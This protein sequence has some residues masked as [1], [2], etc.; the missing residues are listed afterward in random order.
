MERVFNINPFKNLSHEKKVFYAFLLVHLLVWT[1]IAMIRTVM[2]TDTLEGI[3]WGQHLDFGTPKHP[4]LA[5]WLTYFAWAPFKSD[6]VI[7]LMSQMFIIGGFVYIYRLAKFFLDENQAILS[8]I[9]LEGCWCYSYVTGYY[10]FNPDVVLLLM[11]PALAFYFYKC[12]ADDK[13][14]DWMKLGI[15]V[16]LSCLNKYQT[17]LMILPMAIW[18]LFFNRQTFKNKNFYIAVAIAF[19]I[20]L[21]HLLWLIKYD[22]YPLMYFEEELSSP[23][24]YTH[25]TAPL[26]FL[27]VQIGA[28]A[29]SLLIFMACKYKAKSSY[30][31]V[32]YTDRRHLWF[33]ILFGFIPL[34]VHLTLGVS[35]G[36]TMRPRWGFEFLFMTG[37]VLF[38]FLPCK[39]D[40]KTFDFTVKTAYAVMLIIMLIFG[41]L[42]SVE[43]NFRSRYEV[44]PV[45]S[46]FNEIWANK[47]DTPL[48][49][50]GGYIEYTLPLT[51]YGKTHP[52]N[53]LD[54]HGYPS[55]WL[56]M[57]DLKKS[58]AII[59]DRYPEGVIHYTRTTV[60]YLPKDYK[61]VPIPYRFTIT[62]SYNLP[63]EYT[64]YYFII[65][66]M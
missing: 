10:G 12:M 8:V 49:Y 42:L 17:G 39:I 26:L 56:N 30:T 11:L 16:G 23:V 25:I 33:L 44:A 9:L 35:S 55:P 2:Q 15:W 45:M 46:D 54:T 34:I 1:C 51:I 4:P 32:E 27:V 13:P 57:H 22:F 20:F 37:I 60:P 59:I 53:I 6:F 52:A 66:P 28:I 48:K 58:G 21:P 5:A 31:I 38:Y 29:G 36:G 24:W 47:Y 18:A 50:V 65:P 43:K 7:Y 64:I 62:N 40:R 19:F 61:I 3:Y 63:R 14:S 41:G